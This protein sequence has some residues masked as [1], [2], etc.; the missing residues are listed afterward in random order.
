MHNSNK[1]AF[2]DLFHL[3]TDVIGLLL[4]YYIA[5]S[6]SLG[7]TNLGGIREYAWV[8]VIYIPIWTFVMAVNDMYNLTT[9]TYY[10][11]IFRNTLLASVFSAIL[12]A[13]LMYAIKDTMYSRILFFNFFL[14]AVIVM[15][16]E[17]YLVLYVFKFPNSKNTRQVMVIGVQSMYDQFK[18][19]VNKTNIK[20]EV[21]SYIG[22]NETQDLK[23]NT[24]LVNIENFQNDLRTKVIDE[25]YFAL[26]IKYFKEIQEYVLIGEEMGITSRV[27]LDLV[28][29][30]FSRINVASLGTLPMIT[31]HSVS[32][33]RLQLFIKRIIDII[34]AIVGLTL[35][36]LLWLGAIIAI[37]IN[38]PGPVFFVQ[39]RVGKNGRVFKLYKFRSMYMDAEEKKKE[40]EAQN[41]I[42]SGLMFKIKNDSRI[43]PIGKFIRKTSIDELPQFFNVLK[44]DM[45]L[46]GTRPPTVDEVKQY[47]NYHMRRI[48]IKPG[49]TGLWQVSGRS[50]ITDFDEVVKLDTKYIDDWS[51]YLDIKIMI[52]TVLVVFGNRG[53][54]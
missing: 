11:R 48:S 42:K 31:F 37:K 33:N 24:E 16:I 34:G 25:I 47:K 18:Y 39:D 5:Y 20:V 40:M 49:I 7:L 45:S 15:L 30:K 6:V 22:V 19:Y 26:P 23:Q 43:T 4:S 53:A 36:S 13:A 32:L 1:L 50:A 35:T 52:K 29:M 28:E 54:F 41:E 9:F 51:V 38:S 3:I 21:A 46:V 14:I 10:D 27:L 17:K 8:V 44:G 2:F 12:I